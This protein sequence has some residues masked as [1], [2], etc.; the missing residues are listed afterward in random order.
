MT[1]GIASKERLFLC[2]IAPPRSR[3]TSLVRHLSFLFARME[4]LLGTRAYDPPPRD[5][6]RFRVLVDRLWPRGVK[7]DDLEVDAWMKELAPS[8][9]LR[10]W[11]N[12]DPE[13]WDEFRQRYFKE[14]DQLAD[15]VSE[16]LESADGRTILL[17]YG[18]RDE[19][20]NQA[21]AL[22]QWIDKH[23]SKLKA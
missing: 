7:K 23:A 13:R 15:Q 19:E 14:L 8:T 16:L 2:A 5:N 20:H 9:K 21:V 4:F 6:D 10:H 1:R 11:F 17:L 22:K 12:H 18:A 3:T